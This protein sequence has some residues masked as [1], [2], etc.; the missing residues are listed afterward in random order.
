MHT[1]VAPL[2]QL[3]HVICVIWLVLD[4]VLVFVGFGLIPDLLTLPISSHSKDHALHCVSIDS[5]YETRKSLLY[6]YRCLAYTDPKAN[7][8]CFLHR[9]LP[10]LG[11]HADDGSEWSRS[12]VMNG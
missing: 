9:Y 5:H 4:L 11:H 6:G 3:E 1:P 2:T 10:G 12:R 7:D 8:F